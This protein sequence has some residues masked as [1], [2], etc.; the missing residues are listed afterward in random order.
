MEVDGKDIGRLDFELFGKEAPK[1][2]NNFLAFCTGDFNPYLRYKGSHF[3]NVHEQRFITGGDFIRGDGTGAATVYED[4]N[5]GKTME[6]ESGTLHFDEPYLL[7]MSANKEGQTGC[8]F[9]ITLDSMPALNGT[10]HTII[11]RLFK[12][13][14]TVKHLE[15]IQEYRSS[16]DFI[17]RRI[18]SM[19][20]AMGS[21]MNP[22][23]E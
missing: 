22:T 10:K 15:G 5:G 19:P 12:G 8:Q 13:T 14:E 21:E 3:M 18:Q 6:A 4:E 20:M 2:V 11:G 23:K 9:F 16:Q 17:K 7:A 1:T